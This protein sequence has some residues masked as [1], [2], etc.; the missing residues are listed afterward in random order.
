MLKPWQELVTHR[1]LLRALPSR[2]Q[3]LEQG[4]GQ[5][6]GQE[7][8]HLAKWLE[9]PLEAAMRFEVTEGAITLA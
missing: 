3:Q 9:P 6:G 4:G 1:L 7:E 5:G 2:Q 8:I